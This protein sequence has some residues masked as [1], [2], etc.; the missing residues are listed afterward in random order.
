MSNKPRVIITGSDEALGR[1]RI[2]DNKSKLRAES[3]EGKK[4][5]KDLYYAF[6]GGDE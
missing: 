4:V 6:T 1:T 5:D 3:K 2:V